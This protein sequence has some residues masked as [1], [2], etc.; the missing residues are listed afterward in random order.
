MFNRE[1]IQQAKQDFAEKRYC[2]IDNVLEPQYIRALYR[3]VPKLEYGV[4]TCIHNSHNKFR[5][6]Y[7]ESEEFEPAHSA[8]IEQARGKFSYWHYAYW[9]LQ[10]H[11][12]RHNS[13]EVTYFNRVV[14]EDYSIG[15]VVFW[16]M[17]G[18]LIPLVFTIPRDRWA[19]L[20]TTSKPG[21]HF[22]R[23]LAGTIALFCVYASLHFLPLATTVSLIVKSLPSGIVQFSVLEIVES[24][25]AV[26]F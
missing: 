16:R 12:K 23:S 1:G 10:D 15:Y 7:K 11:H 3:E 2:Y 4:W 25:A 6:G 9:L 20:L 18:G 14:T 19:H 17:I 24:C 22:I 21:L 5:H 26:R 13:H 8:F